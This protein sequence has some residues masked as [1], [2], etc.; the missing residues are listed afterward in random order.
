ME[1]SYWLGIDFGT[2]GARAIVVDANGR[3]IVETRAEYLMQTP[4]GWRSALITLFEELPK[5]IC[6]RLVGIAIDG[7][8][9]TVM[10]CEA[11]GNPVG[12]VLMYNDDRAAGV[13]DQI[14]SIAPPN[15]TVI[16]ATSS[17]AKLLWLSQQSGF[18][19]AHKLVHQA[20]WLAFLLH[21][22]LGITDYH[23]ALKLG[24]DVETLA[25]PDWLQQHELR[26]LFPEVRTPGEAIG[27]IL[28]H[29]CDRFSIPSSC[30]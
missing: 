17:F 27:P 28:H 23:N 14:R 21:G 1:E 15:H 2:S 25:Y 24:Y 4:E 19:Q 29:W 11:L 6:Q 12:Q 8:S 30:Y 16:S 10:L 5:Q 9:S 18:E 13:L 7:T 26:S 3:A 22:R 20:D